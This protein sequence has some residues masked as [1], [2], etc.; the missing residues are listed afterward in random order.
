MPECALEMTHPLVVARRDKQQMI[1]VIAIK[2]LEEDDTVRILF[3]S[4]EQTSSREHGGCEVRFGKNDQWR[5]TFSR[6]L[7]LVKKRMDDPTKCAMAGFCHRLQRAVVYKLFASLF[8]YGNDYQGL[9][10]VFLDNEYGD[11]AARVKLR[12]SAGTGT[13]TQSPYW[14][15]AVVHLAGFVLNGNVTN[16]NDTAYVSADFEAL[17]ILEELSEAKSYKLCFLP[18]NRKERCRARR[19]I[20]VQRR[21]KCSL[22]LWYLFPQDGEEKS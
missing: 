2:S 7:H 17:H 22:V 11:A 4:K 3:K 9:E 14:V 15:D 19:H 6:T 5:S 13:F 20:R 8:D 10:E 21:Q 18:T 12:P 16:T 1:E